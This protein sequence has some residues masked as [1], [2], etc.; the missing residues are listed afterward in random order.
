MAALE[1]RRDTL[2]AAE[3]EVQLALVQG[4]GRQARGQ[5]LD[6]DGDS[7]GAFAQAAHQARHADQLDV[8]GHRHGEALPAAPRI[9]AFAIAQALFDLP[10]RRADRCF[11]C[12]RP[13][14]WLH[15]PTG[16]DQQRIVE[17]FAQAVQRVAHRRLAQRQALRGAR[18]VTLAQQ[19]VEHAQQVEIEGLDIHWLNSRYHK[20]KFQK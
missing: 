14:C 19:G 11:Q 10:Q 13:R 15:G 18:D 1:A 7:R 16:A 2:E 3:H 20:T 17:Q 5:V 8:V 12:Q 6:G 9:E 4:F